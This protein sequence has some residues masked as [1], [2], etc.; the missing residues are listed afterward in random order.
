MGKADCKNQLNS[1]HFSACKG[2]GWGASLNFCEIFQNNKSKQIGVKNLTV[3]TF[4]S[5]ELPS[6]IN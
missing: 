1:P 3:G 4:R 6:T 2:R 5:P